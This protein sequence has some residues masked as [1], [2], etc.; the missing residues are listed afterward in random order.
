M[1]KIRKYRDAD[2][3]KVKELINSVLKSIYGKDSGVEKWENFKEYAVFY[4][5]EED[6]NILGTAALKKA[7]DGTIK[8]KRM[9]VDQKIQHKG[10][11]TRLFEKILEYAKKNNV[12]R[13][14]LTTLP[15]MKSGTA[16]YIKQGFKII[17]DP[18]LKDYSEKQI[19]MEK[20]LT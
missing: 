7:D 4:V 3:N 12:K 5:A 9:Y 14:I 2:E 17:D 13:I 11:G 6:S 1:I 8:L 18:K 10:L 19:A 15:E 20:I 16:F